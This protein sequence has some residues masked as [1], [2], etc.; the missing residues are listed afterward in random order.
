MSSLIPAD[1][2]PLLSAALL[3]L[4]VLIYVV[5]D[6]ADLGVGVLF[7]L[8]PDQEDR[9]V[10]V[11]SILPVWDANETWL[12]LAG[13]ALL[14]LFPSA[15]SSILSALYPLIIV[16]LLSLICRGTALELRG[17]APHSERVGWDVAICGGSLLA[18]FCQG[19]AL[20]AIV[21]GIHVTAD[22]YAGGWWDWFSG[23]S[24]ACG[25]AVVCVYLVLG[26]CWLVWRTEGALQARAWK[27]APWL[28]A[29]AIALLA[30]IGAWALTLNAT[31]SQHWSE[32]PFSIIRWMLC[33]LFVAAALLFVWSRKKRKDMT[34]LLAAIF[35]LVVAYFSVAGTLYPFI[36]PPALS[37]SA[38]ASAPSSQLF[39]LGGCAFLVPAILAYSTFSFWV[40][41]GKVKPERSVNTAGE[42]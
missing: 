9:E 37:I 25:L 10:M 26:S 15:Y 11:N 18:A 35:C 12:V 27:R 19:V 14:A 6:G 31:Y 5:L 24:V 23:F 20:G 34:L 4:T 33:A 16:M 3:A 42:I 40:F 13:G 28:G 39:V 7:V 21:Q 30:A 8:T 1:L 17:R 2:I 22:V 41:R 38:A 36:V 29:T 32:W